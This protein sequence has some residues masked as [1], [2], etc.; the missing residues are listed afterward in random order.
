MRHAS[1]FSWERTTDR[2]L[3]VY[4]ESMLA[5][6]ALSVATASSPEVASHASHASH[7]LLASPIDDAAELTG[8]PAALIP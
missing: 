4:S 5:R 2:L 6:A 1:Q 8:V 3:E 7:A